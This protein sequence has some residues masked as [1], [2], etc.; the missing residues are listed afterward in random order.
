[1]DSLSRALEFARVID[2][3]NTIVRRFGAGRGRRR[4]GRVFSWLCECIGAIVFA[5]QFEKKRVE[6]IVL[7]Q[8]C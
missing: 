4:T 8:I 1:M 2:C 5:D 7:V 6:E 3:E